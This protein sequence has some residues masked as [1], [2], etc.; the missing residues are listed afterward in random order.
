MDKMI[1]TV[2]DNEKNAYEGV[3]ALNDLHWE[4]SLTLYATAVIAKDAKGMV[5]V[6]QAAEEGPTGTVLGFAT[7]SLIGL[8]GGPVGL[9]VGGAAGTLAG[10]VFDIAQ[11]GIS[12]DFLAEASN[13]LSPGK[14]AVIAE[15]DEEW[16]T[17]L[18]SRMERL[19]GV[20]IRRARAEFI[21]AQI[22]REIAADKAEIAA[23][24]EEYNQAAGEA[25]A[26]LKAKLDAAE[27]RFQGRR[28]QVNKKIEAVKREGEAKVKS[29]QEQA[30]KAKGETK[31]KLEKR[32]ADIRSDLKPRIGKLEQ[33]W[34]LTQEALRP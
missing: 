22:E 32:I 19:G 28:D 31:A 21:D 5:N 25:K 33:A 23:L 15:I 13:H 7:G 11:L 9:A 3:K 24:R 16:V 20:V 1:V 4:G 34:K 30:A 26:K 29:L 8:L 6:K 12:D 18:D 10:S 14:A 27:K 2:F 17:P